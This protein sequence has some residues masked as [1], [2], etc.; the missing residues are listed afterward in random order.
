MVSRIATC[1]AEFSDVGEIVGLRPHLCSY[2]LQLLTQGC[3]L[4]TLRWQCA[5]T[6]EKKRL[7][8]GCLVCL[9]LTRPPP[10]PAS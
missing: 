8:Q 6:L 1:D 4:T 5:E 7:P 3:W 10:L 2:L 9:V